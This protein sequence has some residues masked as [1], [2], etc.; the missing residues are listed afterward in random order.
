VAIHPTEYLS[1]WHE[2]SL[3]LVMAQA[4]HSVAVARALQSTYLS[5]VQESCLLLVLALDSPAVELAQQSK[6]LCLGLEL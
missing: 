4:F 3:W 5:T 1:Q 2:M 6:S